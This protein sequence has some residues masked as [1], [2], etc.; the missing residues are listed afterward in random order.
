M[1][2]LTGCE[3]KNGGVYEFLLTARSEE[4]WIKGTQVPFPE[5]G[6]SSK[7]SALFDLSPGFDPIRQAF[8]VHAEFHRSLKQMI[9]VN[10]CTGMAWEVATSFYE[11]VLHLCE[12]ASD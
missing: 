10:M 12:T 5:D 7:Y 3:T 9:D 6:P 11:K 1:R 8:F 2:N 4:G